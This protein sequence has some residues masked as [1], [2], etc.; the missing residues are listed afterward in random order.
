MEGAAP[1]PHSEPRSEPRRSKSRSSSNAGA[2]AAAEPRSSREHRRGPSAT[3][4]STAEGVQPQ[5][6]VQLHGERPGSA[7]A[8]KTR[9]AVDAAVDAN[10]QLDDYEILRRIGSGKFSVVYKARRKADG[11]ILAL[12]KVQ[13]FDI[14]DTKARE[15]CLKE[16][17]LLQNLKHENVVKYVDSFFEEGILF[18]VFEWAASGDL[19]RVMKETREASGQLDEAVIWNY[20]EQVCRGLR[21]MHERRMMHRDIKPANIFITGSGVLKLGD[22]GLG[23]QLSNDSIAAFSKVGTP[24]YMSPEVLQGTGYDTKSDVWSLGCVLHELAA[25]R[26]PFKGEDQNLYALFQRITACAFTPLPDS[27]SPAL[28]QLVESMVQLDPEQRPDMSEICKRAAAQ[29]KVWCSKKPALILADNV[30]EKLKLLDYERHWCKPLGIQPLYRTHFAMPARRADAAAAKARL[31]ELGQLVR[32]LASLVDNSLPAL[33]PS[34]PEDENL[35]ATGVLQLCGQLAIETE[36]SVPQLK[37]A[38]G[39]EVCQILDQ[40]CD[41]A[42]RAKRFRWRKSEPIEEEE[43]SGEDGK[44]AANGGGGDEVGQEVAEELDGSDNGEEDEDEAS[45][46]IIMPSVPADE[47]RQDAERVCRDQLNWAPRLQLGRHG[48]RASLTMMEQAAAPIAQA[49]P[50]AR[51]ILDSIAD[52]TADELDRIR[53]IEHRAASSDAC[54]ES[55]AQLQSQ[56]EALAELEA[57]YQRRH[58]NMQQ[59]QQQLQESHDEADAVKSELRDRSHGAT[60]DAPLRAIKLALQRLKVE[61]KDLGLRLSST[62]A[63]IQQLKR[64]DDA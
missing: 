36:C 16:V 26:S 39:D 18:I 7:A 25:L 6:V 47:W 10:S 40:L 22:M 5:D 41:M 9:Y 57:E 59:R 17:K 32:W 64:A 51:R 20:F 35:I 12:K 24:L 8:A 38:Y 63:R 55:L 27:F 21:Y 11:H 34:P 37:R 42:L 15:K 54:S 14:K 3:R 61:N 4:P 52:Q 30:A 29:K 56:R 53:N 19:K 13:V 33:Q 46:R 23:R 62:T 60:D 44:D 58:V 48:W 31:A 45:R 49:A 1:P 28:R 43:R 2:A 50:S